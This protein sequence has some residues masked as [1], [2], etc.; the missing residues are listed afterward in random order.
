MPSQCE[1]HGSLKATLGKRNRAENPHS[2]EAKL[3]QQMTFGLL[4]I[5]ILRHPIKILNKAY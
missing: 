2:P 3:P 1:D 5:L 4:I